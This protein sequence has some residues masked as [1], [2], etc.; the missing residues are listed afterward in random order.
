LDHGVERGAGRASGKEHVIDKDHGPVGDV[1]A[2]GAYWKRHYNTRLG[3]GT[4]ERFVEVF[5]RFA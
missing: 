3:R 1:D 2:L 5:R 4:V